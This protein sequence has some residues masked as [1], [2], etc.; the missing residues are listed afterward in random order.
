MD[1]NNT[2]ILPSL[3]IGQI[4][5]FV[6]YG[7]ALKRVL[8]NQNRWHVKIVYNL[9]GLDTRSYAATTY[10]RSYDYLKLLENTTLL[11]CKGKLSPLIVNLY[12]EENTIVCGYLGEFFQHYLLRGLDNASIGPRA[13]FDY[14]LDINSMNQG[15]KKFF[16]PNIIKSAIEL[17]GVLT[18]D[19]EF[20]GKSRKILPRLEDSGIEFAYGYGIED[21]HIWNFRIMKTLGTIRAFTTDLDYFSDKIN[22]FW[23]LGYFYATF[24]WIRKTSPYTA[25]IAEKDLASLIE[26][27]SLKAQ[28]MF[29]L[30]ALSSYCGYKDSL[31]SLVKGEGFHELEKEYK[32]IE[33]LDEK[34]SSL[35]KNLLT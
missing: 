22:C 16:T 28:F 24:R 12:P 29:W 27:H 33:V 4:F 3:S 11:K 14:L 9:V 10:M 32:T 30:G 8:N 1:T 18:G 26:R 23:E 13:V 15:Y 25:S 6:K 21:P 31:L 7:Y 19:F 17:S 34:V 5:P 20:L 35:A 2:G